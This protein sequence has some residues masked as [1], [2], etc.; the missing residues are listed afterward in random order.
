MTGSGNQVIEKGTTG[1]SLV[2]NTMTKKLLK[3]TSLKVICEITA[4]I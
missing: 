4:N 2:S 3:R 1:R